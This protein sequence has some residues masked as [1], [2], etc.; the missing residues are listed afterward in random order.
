[1]G[2]RVTEATVPGGALAVRA[3]QGDWTDTQKAALAQIGVGDA[4]RGDQL[5][6]LHV[7]QRMR[8]DPF[9]KEI[10]MIGRWDASLGRKKWTIQVAI[11]GF[12]SKS[13]EHPEYAGVGNAEWCGPDGEWRDV[14]LSDEPPVAARFTVHRHD[15]D[16]PTTAVAHYREYVQ[17]KSDGKSPT[18]M[19]AT[20]PAGQLAKCA[21]ALARRRAFPRALGGVYAPE[22]IEHL[23]NPPQ[24]IVIEATRDDTPA[25]PEWDDLIKAA[26]VA[27]NRAKLVEVWDLARAM[28]PNDGALLERIAAAGERVKAKDEAAPPSPDD[29][30]TSSEPADSAA[31]AD[32][33]ADKT[34][35]NRLFAL[36]RDGGVSGAER[37]LR[38]RI[39]TRVL[40]RPPTEPVTTF[41]E[42]TGNEI[43]TVNEFLQRHK[44]TGDLTHTL[45]DLG[46][47]APPLS[48]PAP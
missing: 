32:K 34:Q 28:R 23:D 15:W 17:F 20:K 39:V 3:D 7:A 26:E 1:L 6:F 21:E 4:P 35:R 18:A 2:K 30:A 41:E 5:V 48:E 13:E 45:A 42:L 16:H 8:L 31:S 10:Y 33:P 44:D 25:E 37:D 12:R 29:E 11:D 47:D 40:N 36:L 14:W 24:R 38:L 43:D 22:E 46:A 19:W 27:G 9:N